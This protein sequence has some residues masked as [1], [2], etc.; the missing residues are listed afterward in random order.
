MPTLLASL[1][2]LSL[3]AGPHQDRPA[4]TEPGLSAEFLY[5]GV[6]RPARIT[7]TSPRSFGTV[8]LA[9]MDPDGKSLADP[10]DVHPGVVDLAEKL[11][12][13]WKIRRTSYLQ[14]IDG[15]TPVGSALVLQPM[16]SR[17]VPLTEIRP[18]PVTGNAHS[19]IVGWLDENALPPPAMPRTETP[20]DQNST[21]PKPSAPGSAGGAA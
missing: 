14:L 19:R 3:T 5:N 1:I 9:L 2:A 17:M 10:I 8:T 21:N 20:V 6:N 16:L 11:P 4:T 12:V 7:V 15:S 13:I 18:H